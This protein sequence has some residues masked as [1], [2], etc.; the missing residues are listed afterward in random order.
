MLMQL[1]ALHKVYSSD[2]HLKMLGHLF[3]HIFTNG[4]ALLVL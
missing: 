2:W 4:L 3:R 1:P